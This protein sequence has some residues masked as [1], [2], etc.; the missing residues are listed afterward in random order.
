MKDS[1]IVPEEMPKLS[2]IPEEQIK[3]VSKNKK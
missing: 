2:S 1:G 3:K